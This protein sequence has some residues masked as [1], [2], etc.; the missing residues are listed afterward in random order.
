M[1]I[2]LFRPEIP[3]NTGNIGRLCHCTD[4][5][6]HIIDRPAFSL[7]EAAVRRA[8]LD[9]WEQLNLR[10]HDDWSAFLRWKET[11]NGSARIV[12]FSRFAS[13]VYS[14]FEYAADDI[15]LFGGESNGFPEWLKPELA[16]RS[17]VQLLRIPVS[18]RC[19]S[20]NLANTV[21]LALYEA[22]RQLGFPGLDR[23]Y[24]GRP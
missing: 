9:Y 3:P 1:H 2:A 4:S 21:S 12:A 19:R 5:A 7:D 14:E 13:D 24:S 23:S 20:L 6:L 10:L 18:S 8:G 16:S 22:L 11:E 17:D 15:L